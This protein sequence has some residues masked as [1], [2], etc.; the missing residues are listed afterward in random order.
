MTQFRIDVVVDPR[1]AV[2]GTKAVSKGLTDVQKKANRTQLLLKQAF[3]GVT[4]VLLIKEV[5]ALADSYTNLQNRLRVVTG[6]QRDLIDTTEELLQVAN[7]SRSSFESTAELYSRLALAT[8]ELNLEGANLIEV[9]ESINKAIILSGASAKEA[10]NGLIQLSQGLASGRLTGDELRSTLEQLPVV[11]DVIAKQL[12]VTRGELRKLGSEGKIT[13]IQII[14]AFQNSKDELE[15][16]FAK[17]VPTLGQ[18]FVV[19]RNNVIAF[20]GRINEGAGILRGFG[21]RIRFVGENLDTI[22]KSLGVVGVSLLALK[23]APAIQGFFDVA[24]AVKAGTAVRLGSIKA[25][26]LQNASIAANA[27]ANVVAEAAEVA[28]LKGVITLTREE[29]IHNSAIVGK[30]ASILALAA[31]EQS[32]IGTRNQLT[33]ATARLTAAEV[34]SGNASAAAAVKVTV[35]SQAMGKARAA[36]KAF[37]AV[38]AANPIGAVL[39]VL[40]AIISSLVIFR[41]EI[42]LT[43]DGLGTLGDFFTIFFERISTAL[44]IIP[45]LFSTAFGGAFA[46]IGEFLKEF[47]FEF[48]DIPRFIAAIFDT[49]TGTIGAAFAFL[50]TIVAEV[51]NNFKAAFAQAV[52]ATIDALEFLPKVMFAINKT[53]FQ[54]LGVL[55]TGFIDAAKFAKQALD[56]LLDGD[57]ASAK[58]FGEAAGAA[59]ANSLD[60]ATSDVGTKLLNNLADVLETDVIPK[61]EEPLVGGFGEVFSRAGAAASEAFNANLAGGFVNDVIVGADRLAADRA[62]TEATEKQT[63]ADKQAAVAAALRAEGIDKI[64]EATFREQKLLQVALTQGAREAEIQSK[65]LKINDDLAKAGLALGLQQQILVEQTIRKNLADQENLATAQ[66]LITTEELLAERTRLVNQAYDAGAISADKYAAAMRDIDLSA[67]EASKTIGGGLT[68]G[69]AKVQEEFSDL[70]G[71]TADVVGEAFNG[72]ADIISSLGEDGALTFKDLA[73]SVVKS[74]Q[75]IVAELLIL[76]AIQAIGGLFG[77]TAGGGGGFAD[78]LAGFGT[79]A[80]GSNAAGA[81][82]PFL[83]GEEGP[84]IFTPGQTGSITPTDNTI[85]SL[86]AG[87]GGGGGQ[88]VVVQAPAPEVNVNTI[89]VKDPSEIPT[90]I[91]SPDGRQAIRNVIREERSGI[92]RDLG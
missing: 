82:K 31:T 76:K 91:E 2:A 88:T 79:A 33:A 57:V 28:R 84:E 36:V 12:G 43:E 8:R 42:S 44:S 54:S 11:A 61:M 23:F 4:A 5:A 74:I 3:V 72:V 10:N 81:N 78:S 27:A 55:V 51:P 15:E 85:E 17:T 41:N 32:L 29:L 25:I 77:G 30:N 65:I 16:G 68:L 39:V 46:F 34:A 20:L 80:T 24:A 64:T 86:S 14:K 62:K 38:I 73:G 52:N 70:A 89:V 50:F 21:A 22:V 35:L 7:R 6:S 60:E 69:L 75:K 63:K 26:N 37:T 13:S 92:K 45:E 59:V 87:A 49:V 47:E 71:P 58:K 9:T 18:S 66:E 1:K 56:A 90:G 83:V 19:L 40:T 53:I 48:A 67:A